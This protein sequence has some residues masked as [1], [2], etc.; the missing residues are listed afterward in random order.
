ML[1][2]TFACKAVIPGLGA[3]GTDVDALADTGDEGSYI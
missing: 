3:A 2:F 1:L